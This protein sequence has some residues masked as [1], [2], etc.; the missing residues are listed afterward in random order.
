M[1]SWEYEPEARITA[2]CIYERFLAIRDSDVSIDVDK[3]ET[4]FLEKAESVL[5]KL[6][7]EVIPAVV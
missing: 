1:E 6:I 2:R 3:D 5:E 4:K 7:P